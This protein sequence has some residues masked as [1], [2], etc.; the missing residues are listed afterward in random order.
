F[1]ELMEATAWSEYGTE[2]GNPK[3]ANCMVH[4]GYEA[5]AVDATFNSIGGI[6]AAAKATIF[7]TY[8]DEQALKLLSDTVK[9]VHAYN[10]L[11]HIEATAQQET[12]AGAS[13][14]TP[15][16]RPR[17]QTLWK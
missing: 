14:R 7:G 6:F 5:S 10:P 15:I 17:T 1:K 2:S 3:C 11:V 9:P 12:R 13:P 8:E 16:Q 4:S